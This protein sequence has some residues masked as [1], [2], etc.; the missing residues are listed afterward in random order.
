[1]NWSV[2]EKDNLVVSEAFSRYGQKTNRERNL[3]VKK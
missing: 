2:K 1:L 3:K